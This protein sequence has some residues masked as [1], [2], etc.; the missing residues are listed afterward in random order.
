MSD[1][2]SNPNTINR[3]QV[4]AGL[5]ALAATSL[6][7]QRLAAQNRSEAD[8]LIIGG[9]IAGAS[10]ALHLAE[11]GRDVTLLERG[12]KLPYSFAS[13]LFSEFRNNPIPPTAR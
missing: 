4:I 11:Q 7:P 2:K 1:K 5:G 9:G 12:I 13:K 8:I 3:R 6:L 10:T